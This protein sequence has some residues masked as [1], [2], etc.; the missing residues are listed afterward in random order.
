[1]LIPTK[2]SDTNMIEF[3]NERFNCV[4]TLQCYI[5]FIAKTILT[6]ISV[7]ILLSY[8]I[9]APRFSPRPP[10]VLNNLRI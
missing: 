7:A 3:I 4:F 9:L 10:L 2:I 5:K 1:M 6:A 8:V